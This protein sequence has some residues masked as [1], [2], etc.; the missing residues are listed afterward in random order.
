[1]NDN[2]NPENLSYGW[3]QQGDKSVTY[4]CAD[5]DEYLRLFD[6]HF[7]DFAGTILEIGPGT[8]YL[9]KYLIDSFDVKYTILDIEKNI[10]ELKQLCLSLKEKHIQN[11]NFINS[12]EYEKV[13]LKEYDLL[14]STFCLPETPEYYWRDI[15]DKVKVNNCFMIDDGK[16]HG[17]YDNA[18]NQWLYT[19]FNSCEETEWIHTISGYEQEGIQLTIGKN[20]KKEVLNEK[21]N[22]YKS[23]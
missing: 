5:Q 2:K 15:F 3:A 10:N 7:K 9:C 22:S 19:N 23:R 20:T 1:M 4:Y 11:I 6:K 17:D 13:F 21:S 8:G 16:D 14:I 12:S 18:R